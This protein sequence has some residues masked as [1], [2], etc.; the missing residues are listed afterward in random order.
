MYY[1]ETLKFGDLND[2]TILAIKKIK[3][4]Y[5]VNVGKQK[6]LRSC[7]GQKILEEYLK[8]NASRNPIKKIKSNIKVSVYKFN[9]NSKKCLIK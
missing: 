1:L 3:P 4:D 5:I 6:T 7:Q 9:S 8:V 2:N